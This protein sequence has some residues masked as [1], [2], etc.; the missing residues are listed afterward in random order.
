MLLIR[1]LY[2]DIRNDPFS[3]TLFGNAKDYRFCG[4]AEAVAGDDGAASGLLRI[5]ADRIG[6]NKSAAKVLQAHRT[7]IFGKGGDPWEIKGHVMNR[8]KVAKVLEEQD[9]VL[10]R[11]AVLRCRVRYFTEGVVL[12]S[13]EYVRGFADMV[14]M[15]RKRKRALNAN[16]LKGASWGDVTVLQK[17]RSQ[18]FF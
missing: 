9:G 11:T 4:Y 7:L 13:A 18:V 8:K 6:A 5:W 17:L 3:E 12:G 1:I 10:P 2:V 16:P 15:D 14:K